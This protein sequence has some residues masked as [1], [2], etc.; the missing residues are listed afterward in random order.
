MRT[1]IV[2]GT[3]QEVVCDLIQCTV[4]SVHILTGNTY[5]ANVPKKP[6][7]LKIKQWPDMK[8]AQ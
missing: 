4:Y 3:E 6:K 1:G 8:P 7:D 2:K 5:V